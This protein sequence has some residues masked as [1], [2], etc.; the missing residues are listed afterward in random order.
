MTRK[1]LLFSI[2][3]LFVVNAAYAED[4]KYQTTIASGTIFLGN[5]YAK[6]KYPILFRGFVRDTDS[7][8]VSTK[9]VDSFLK[10]LYSKS[11][12]IAQGWIFFDKA[13]KLI[14][15]KSPLIRISDN[16]VIDVLQD[17]NL[18]YDS[19]CDKYESN[20]TFT[21]DTGETVYMSYCNIGSCFVVFP[22]DLY[23][24]YNFT[25]SD[26]FDLSAIPSIDSIWVPLGAFSTC[27]NTRDVFIFPNKK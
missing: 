7:I 5:I 8:T 24:G 2:I 3:T 9:D 15:G 17:Y 25:T 1:L 10:S 19:L 4:N 14:F 18:Y 22:I 26:D 12:F 6:N 21:L 20:V 16:D 23:Y 11:K 13:Y 27:N